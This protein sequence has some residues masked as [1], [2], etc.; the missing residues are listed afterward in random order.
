M[1]QQPQIN[2]QTSHHPPLLF[3]DAFLERLII[4]HPYKCHTQHDRSDQLYIQLSEGIVYLWKFDSVLTWTI[5]SRTFQSLEHANFA[6][7]NIIAAIQDWGITGVNF[8]YVEESQIDSATFIVKYTKA[9]SGGTAAKAFFPVEE[10]SELMIYPLAFS[11]GQINYLRQILAHEIGHIFGLRHEFA[12]RE[13]DPAVQFGPSN[14]ASVM[15]YNSPPVIQES[16]KA[17][18]QKLYAKEN[19]LTKFAGSDAFP[20][21]RL[22]PF[23]G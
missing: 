13:N 6:Q 21:E 4:P 19:P 8:R 15:N 22:L 16:D 20:I 18:L 14:P 2:L 11:A 3:D 12:I 23:S 5:K 1:N 7:Q 17:W 10:Q 9:Q